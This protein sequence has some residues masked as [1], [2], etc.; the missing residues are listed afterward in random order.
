MIIWTWCECRG[1]RVEYV[2]K[3]QDGD[4][5]IYV[6]PDCGRQITKG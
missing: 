6:C 2:L 4:K 5:K 1:Y 3:S